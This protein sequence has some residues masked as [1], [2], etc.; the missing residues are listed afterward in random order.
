MSVQFVLGASGSGKSTYIYNKIINESMKNKTVN[1]ILLVPEQYSM[2]LQRKMVELHPAGGTMNI[3]VIGFNRLAYR[4]FDEL[5]KKNGKVLEDFGKSMLIRQ[6]AGSI[7]DELQIYGSSLDKPG[8][9]DEIKSLM[10]E[11]YQYDIKGDKLSEMIERLKAEGDGTS[12]LE[13]KLTDMLLIHDAFTK[14]LGDE[15]IVA[16][17][18]TELLVQCIPSSELIKKSVI[19]MDGFTGFTPIQL[20]VVEQ[21]M[22]HSMKVYSVLTIDRENSEKENVAEHEL[23]YLTRKTI[24]SICDRAE[25]NN[26]SIMEPIYVEKAAD[27]S[28][29]ELSWLEANLFRYPYKR[30]E[31]EVEHIAIT[32]YGNMREEIAGAAATIR[33]LVRNEGYR[34]KDFAIITGALTQAEGLFHQ[35]MPKYDIPYFLDYSIPVKN[36]PFIDGICHAIHCVDDGFSYDS[37]FAFLKSGAVSELNDDDIE[38]MDNYVLSKGIKGLWM[39]QRAWGEELDY[40][41]E[42]VL[43]IFAPFIKNKGL[44]KRA[45][46]ADFVNAVLQF[47]ERLD[48]ETRL[49]HAAERYGELGNHELARLYEGLYG[50]IGEILDKMLQIM[51]EQVVS[52]DEFYELF[53]LGLKDVKMGIIPSTLDM[54][55]VGDITRTRLDGI[56]VIFMLDANDG[57]I[58]S[59]ENPAQIISDRDKEK[60]LAFGYELA[61]TDKINVYVEQFYLYMSM[62]K[63]QD[64]LYISY[65]MTGAD[66][67]AMRPS[68]IIE[69]IC[70]IFPRLAVRDGKKASEAVTTKEASVEIL[71]GFLKKLMDGDMQSLNNLNSLYRLYS[72]LGEHELLSIIRSG[73]AYSNIPERLTRD[74]YG[75]IQLKL[76]TQSV[77]RLEQYAGCA[78]SYFLKYILGLRERQIKELNTI[79]IGNILHSSMERLYRH[80]HDNMGNDWE[81]L[82][83]DERDKLV[84]T[85]VGNAFE[86]EFDDDDGKVQYLKTV[87]VRIGQRTAEMLRNITCKDILKPE[88]FEYKFERPLEHENKAPV[89][90]KGIVDRG[91]VYFDREQGLVRLRI[92]DYKSGNYDFRINELYEGLQLQLAVYM[93]V[94]V[95]LVKEQYGKG[96]AEELKIVPEGMYYYQFK[97]P[98]VDAADEAKAQL[99]REKKLTLKGINNAD[100]MVNTMADFAMKKAGELADKILAGDISKKPVLNKGKAACEYCPYKSV[101]RFDDRYGG[102]EYRHMRYGSGDKELVYQKIVSDLGGKPN[103]VDE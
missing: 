96:Y 73:I 11:L 66:N 43:E 93:N 91:D 63:P 53:E 59:G 18:I 35:L 6:V 65:V 102:N 98:Y 97:D 14:R 45:A 39:W 69:R 94:M 2:I 17:E 10:S 101:C 44:L 42:C 15:Y 30:Y 48:Y 16:E 56:K 28:R 8:F 38:L 86:A 22:L 27:R 75:L 103:G 50:K 20:L 41:R 62:T 32:R 25:A 36:N 58:P 7:K 72:D 19:V 57:I 52:I 33:S 3:D 77:S 79:S 89:T 26:I 46:I 21:L 47:M 51:A 13:K 80:V 40:A 23:F 78:Y 95:A 92:I 70:N 64:R 81:G 99:E 54:V 4:V 37:M 88:F 83:D 9:I 68:Y 55:I 71:I 31:D 84:E 76:S 61:P 100:G 60:L 5:G 12:L 24:K 90:L 34:Y 82:A 74:V 67:E 87:L 85:F 29:N 1:Y 49:G